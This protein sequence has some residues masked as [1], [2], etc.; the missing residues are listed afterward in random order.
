MPNPFVRLFRRMP[1]PLA[2]QRTAPSPLDQLADR[3]V[4]ACTRDLPA[5]TVVNEDAEDAYVRAFVAEHIDA[6]DEFTAD[7]NDATLLQRHHERLAAIA[8]QELDRHREATGRYADVSALLTEL[9]LLA[10]QLRDAERRLSGEAENWGEIL[11]GHLE[12][13]EPWAAATGVK[14][15]IAEALMPGLP[16]EVDPPAGDDPGW[17]FRPFTAA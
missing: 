1:R 5:F 10:K 16:T 4:D 2:G 9:G 7:L 3:V 11:T 14:P 12:T 15:T 6:V 8:E 13:F 17:T